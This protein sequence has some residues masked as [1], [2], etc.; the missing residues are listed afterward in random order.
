MLLA[1]IAVNALCGAGT[2]LMTFLATDEQLRTITFWSLG[3]LGGATWPGVL[4]AAP[5]ILLGALMLPL[6][7]RALNALTI[8]EQGA[9]SLGVP[10]T[11]VKWVTVTLIALSVGAGVAVAGTIGFVGL[12]VPHLL[13]LLTGPD[14][15]TL[16]PASALAGATLLVLADLLARTVVTPAEL[17]IGIIT[18]LIGAPFFLHLLRARRGQER[19]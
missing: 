12:V 19:P 3:T 15:R 6:L 10:V 7:G 4:S 16:L 17:P 9:A 2:G 1:G 14:H 8:G 5:L 13:R 11:A 18:A